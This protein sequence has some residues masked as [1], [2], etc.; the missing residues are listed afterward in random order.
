MNM[1]K[2]IF[3]ISVM[4]INFLWLGYPGGQASDTTGYLTL[5]V[6][7]EENRTT[8]NLT[9]FNVTK[10]VSAVGSKLR[11]RYDIGTPVVDD[12]YFVLALDSSGSMGY[13]GDSDQGNAVIY[14]V[15]R[16]IEDTIKNYPSKNFSISIVSWDDDID[17]ASYPFN[18]KDPKKAKLISINNISNEIKTKSVF[19]QLV[20]GKY[21][22]CDE[23]DHTNISKAIE[24]SIDI[25]DPENNPDN[26][27]HRTS[28]FIILVT[29]ASEY[30]AC[31][32]SLIKKAEDEGYA[33]YVI[34]MGLDK[35]SNMLNHLKALSGNKKNR[36]QE[37]EAVGQF[38]KDD[39]LDALNEALRNAINEPVAENVTISESFYN[40]IYPSK[41]ASVK[42]KGSPDSAYDIE[43]T[44]NNDSTIELKLNRGL[45]PNNITEVTFDADLVLGKLPISATV[46]SG[47][48][49]YVPASNNTRSYIKFIWLKKEP[50]DLDLP[51]INITVKSASDIRKTDVGKLSPKTQAGDAF[52]LS[53]LSIFGILFIILMKR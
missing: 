43:V 8:H 33:I 21:Y 3:M 24:A 50:F 52:G 30:T 22:S 28:K 10:S 9:N 41:N 6:T 4:L 38:L 42:I 13:G 51:E 26:Y 35:N 5:Q 44:R 39:L 7:G 32:E 1:S 45:F 47:P 48:I 18:N 46:G 31:S 15:P 14:A 37:L 53:I 36:F 34:G 20:N 12:F 27:Y 49:S 11:I 29:G 25:L 23:T 2:A 19:A 17:F 40:Y 16:F